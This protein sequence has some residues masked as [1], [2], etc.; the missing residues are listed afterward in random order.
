M[1][2]ATVR[3][4]LREWLR[5]HRVVEVFIGSRLFPHEEPVG[6]VVRGGLAGFALRLAG[7]AAWRVGSF[8]VLAHDGLWLRQSE[9]SALLGREVLGWGW[10][11]A[12][13]RSLPLRERHGTA[14]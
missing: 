5:R 6:W 14:W 2:Y 8:V 4:R 13:V 11:G 7:L 10:S 3:V 1:R 9:A 12:P